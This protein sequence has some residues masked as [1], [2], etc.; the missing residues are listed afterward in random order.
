MNNVG[1]CL[2]SHSLGWRGGCGQCESPRLFAWIMHAACAEPAPFSSICSLPS[3]AV[4]FRGTDVA[5]FERGQKEEASLSTWASWW[6]LVFWVGMG[7]GT[8]AA[9]K[10]LSTSKGRILVLC[11][12]PGRVV[13][14]GGIAEGQ[15]RR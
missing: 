9:P 6:L 1:V 15:L 12:S 11:V 3:A 13:F 14:L 10:E 5:P 4:R 7:K 2:S 8:P